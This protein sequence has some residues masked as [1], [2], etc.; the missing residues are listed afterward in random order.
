MT[1]IFVGWHAFLNIKFYKSVLG[2]FPPRGG[3]GT[4]VS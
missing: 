3:A 2:P 4:V 1:D